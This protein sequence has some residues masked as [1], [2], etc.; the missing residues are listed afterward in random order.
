MNLFVEWIKAA[1]LEVQEYLTMVGR[2]A[3]APP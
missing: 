2:A 3:R 1:L